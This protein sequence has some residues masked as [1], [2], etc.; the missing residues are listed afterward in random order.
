MWRVKGTVT[1][2]TIVCWDRGALSFSKWSL[3]V[4]LHHLFNSFLKTFF[5]VFRKQS[6]VLEEDIP[7]C[8]GLSNLL[9][10]EPMQITT[11]SA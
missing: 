9:S 3:L 1:M 2:K 5:I 11:S 7:Q 10:S 4:C 6:M 8:Q